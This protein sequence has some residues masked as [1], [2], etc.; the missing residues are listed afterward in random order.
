RFA[1][2]LVPFA[3]ALAG[4]TLLLAWWHSGD[5]AASLQRALSVL[6]AACPCAVGL[7]LPLAYSASASSAA[8][9][10]VLFRDPAAMEALALA[11][12]I[13]FDKTG[14]LTAGRLA[15][16]GMA[17]SASR[18]DLLRWAA[19]AETGIAHPVASAIRAAAPAAG[20]VQGSAVRSAQ[21]TC[22]TSADGAE[23]VLVGTRAW[24]AANG[25]AVSAPPHDG[26]GS[27]IE[28]ARNGQWAGA[29][30]LQDQARPEAAGAIAALQGAGLQTRLVT[31]D[32]G[33]PALDAA[34]AAGIAPGLVHA[35]CLPADKEAIVRAAPGPVVFVGDGVND[36]LALAAADCG[37]A[38]RGAST[39][40]V[41][42][43][44]V[45]IASGGID[46]V[47][48]AWRHAR[49]T[50]KV[51]RQNLAFSVVYNLAILGLAAA[52]T[53]PPAAA[54]AAML[55]SSLSVIANAARLAR[56][57]GTPD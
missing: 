54:A 31:G 8:R 52:G 43:A 17:G 50:V 28:V 55:A 20:E 7:A 16:T 39:A 45:V 33:A 44:G 48:L 19:A 40:A 37:I 42:T 2:V 1:R 32:A 18:A 3:L 56:M 35:S 26:A 10:G 49:R 6:V 21:G 11:R 14:T 13:Q 25:V 47:V 36:A 34:R 9:H 51:V 24:L 30:R 57:T 15:V 23:S 46:T 5:F 27:W 4:L 53:V 41:A 29:L 22:W 12:E 38:V